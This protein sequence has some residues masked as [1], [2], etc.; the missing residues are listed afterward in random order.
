MVI[1]IPQSLLLT[2][3][4]VASA[5]SIVKDGKLCIEKPNAFQ[6]TFLAL[7]ELFILHLGGFFI[8][9]GF[10]QVLYAFLLITGLTISFV[11]HGKISVVKHNGGIAVFSLGFVLAIFYVGGFFG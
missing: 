11:N 5:C 10:C 6:S 3:Y 9:V 8:N 7:L 2:W 1:G 4:F